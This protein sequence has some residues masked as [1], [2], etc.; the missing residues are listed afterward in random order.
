MSTP[1]N[2]NT[3]SNAVDP[4]IVT[5]L[6]FGVLLVSP[7]ASS[8]MSC[9]RRPTGSTSTSAFVYAWLSVTLA[10]GDG[11]SAVTFTVSVRPA[12]LI[13]VLTSAVPPTVS[14]TLSVCEGRKLVMSKLTE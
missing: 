12:T 8:A 3:L 13:V 7:G 2:M 10:I 6:A 9:G 14:D 5:W 11:V 1:F 4:P